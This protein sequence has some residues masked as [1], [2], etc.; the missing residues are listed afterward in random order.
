MK[1]ED[2]LLTQIFDQND[3]P[4]GAEFLVNLK[5]DIKSL[6]ESVPP[7]QLSPER[8]RDAILNREIAPR[9]RQAAWL[10]WLSPVAGALF[11]F[12]YLQSMRSHVAP[13]LIENRPPVTQ[14]RDLA[15]NSPSPKA[16]PLIQIPVEEPEVKA[17]PKPE[18]ISK[19]SPSSRTRV[20]TVH[21]VRIERPSPQPVQKSEPKQP[22]DQVAVV[23][24]NDENSDG[25]NIAS[26]VDHNN[27]T[28]GG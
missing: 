15:L 10:W 26:E 1:R 5:K 6:R 27:V 12:M 23:I 9:R 14:N 18:Q 2:Q 3:S 28:L 24:S 11:G 13:Q 16:E 4:D 20:R 19:H 21:R 17:S 25:N 7:C 8:L 22:E